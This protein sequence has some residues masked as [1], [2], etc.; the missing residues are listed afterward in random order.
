MLCYFRGVLTSGDVPLDLHVRDL[1]KL[2]EQ[3]F[4]ILLGTKFGQIT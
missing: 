2:P 4:Q 3:S 1:A